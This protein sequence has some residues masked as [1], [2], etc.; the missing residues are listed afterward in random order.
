MPILAL[1][2]LIA[3]LI[4]LAITTTCKWVENAHALE[5]SKKEADRLRT[6]LTMLKETLKNETLRFS[7]EIDALNNSHNK[8]ITNIKELHQR[9]AEELKK[10][11]ANAAVCKT[12]LEAKASGLEA[13]NA[14]LKTEKTNLRADKTILKAENEQLS[15]QIQNLNK[16]LSG[17]GSP[18]EELKVNILKLL[19]KQ[20]N[21]QTEQIAQSL[22][23]ELQVAKFHLEEMK[24]DI[25]LI[26]RASIS[27]PRVEHLT[28]GIIHHFDHVPVWTIGQK[29]RKYLIDNCEV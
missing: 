6:E 5:L 15:V 9:E 20:D 23:L 3:S 17:H 13:K 10:E 18:L 12:E 25:G 19:F 8:E 16:T 29:G 2:G 27:A 4:L 7:T 26:K 14:D 21:L 28:D 11:I 24:A 22:N 1:W